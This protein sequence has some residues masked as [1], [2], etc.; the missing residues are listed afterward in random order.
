MEALVID[1]M[2]PLVDSFAEYVS[3]TCLSGYEETAAI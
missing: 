2:K 3:N 1:L